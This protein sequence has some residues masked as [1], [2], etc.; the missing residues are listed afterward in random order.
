[1]TPN[2]LESRIPALF[3]L[4]TP[5]GVVVS[6]E[7]AAARRIR[8]QKD[9]VRAKAGGPWGREHDEMFRVPTQQPGSANQDNH[10]DVASS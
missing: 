1:M 4:P 5:A 8:L 3:P 10:T 2:S 9:Q 6:E 7:D